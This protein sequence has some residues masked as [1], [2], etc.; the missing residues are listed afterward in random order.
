MKTLYRISFRADT[1]TNENSSEGS[2]YC[3][4]YSYPPHYASQPLLRFEPS[5]SQCSTLG[6]YPSRPDTP[7]SESS[8]E[9]SS[10]TESTMFRGWGK[11][12]N[13]SL[14]GIQSGTEREGQL[15]KINNLVPRALFP[16]FGGPSHLQSQGKAPW[17]RG[18]KII[19][20]PLKKNRNR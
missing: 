17:G 1:K 18:W 9:R 3:C 10:Y 5:F 11:D 14:K 20:L 15:S 8:S 6:V 12:F 13:R 19:R 4:G 16:G 7:Y 2:S